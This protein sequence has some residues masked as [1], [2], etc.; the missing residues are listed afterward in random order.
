MIREERV[1]QQKWQALAAEAD[2]LDHRL[3]GLPHLG[4][5]VWSGMRAGGGLDG[6]VE[7]TAPALD[8]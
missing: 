4:A 5:R 2:A 7:A 8:E 6:Y 1:L 3:D